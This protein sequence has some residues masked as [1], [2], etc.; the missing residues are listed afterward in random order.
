MAPSLEHRQL[1]MR[2]PAWYRSRATGWGIVSVP[3]FPVEVGYVADLAII[4]ALQSRFYE[5]YLAAATRSGLPGGPRPSPVWLTWLSI[6][7]VKVTRADFLATF[8]PNPGEH[9]NRMTARGNAHW[10]VTPR[11][12]VRP[13]EVPGFWGLLEVSGQGLRETRAPEYRP[14][15][16]PTF[17]LMATNMLVALQGRRRIEAPSVT[18]YQSVGLHYTETVESYL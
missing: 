13:D 5:R 7:E 4:G 3:E 15:D 17:H 9:A 11:A 12:M 16:L 10:V 14:V 2:I 18:R 6:F 1:C 8:G